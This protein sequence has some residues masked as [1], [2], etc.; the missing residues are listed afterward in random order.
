M[1]LVF[2]HPPASMQS[3]RELRECYSWLYRLSEQLNAALQQTDA[4]ILSRVQ[5]QMASASNPG[6]P[7][8]VIARTAQELRTLIVKN[9]KVVEQYRDE[10]L[11]ELHESYLAISDFGTLRSEITREI[12]D[13]AQGTLNRFTQSEEYTDVT[14][15]ILSLQNAVNLLNGYRV[16]SD[17]YIQSGLLYYDTN[18]MPVYGVAI[19]DKLKRITDGSGAS[20][21]DKRDITCTI[22]SDRISF[23]MGGQEVA[24][25]SNSSL[26]ITS[27]R[28]LSSLDLGNLVATVQTGGIDW[29]W[30]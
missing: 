15:G 8:A 11:S 12:Q 25:L 9:A 28:I 29:R 23:G 19:G 13:T 27:A 1:Q 7:S 6:S 22:T 30:R 5:E 21:L 24:Y 14:D 16:D 17:S 26:Y 20:V 10:I 2:D 3:Q 4:Q 18:G